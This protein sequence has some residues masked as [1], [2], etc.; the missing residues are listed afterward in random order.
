MVDSSDYATKADLAW[1]GTD[2]RG[3]MQAMRGELRAEMQTSRGELRAEMRDLRQ[4]MRVGFAELRTEIVR[5]NSELRAAF[6]D[7][8]SDHQR[9]VLGAILGQYALIIG[10]YGLIIRRLH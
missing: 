7:R 3:D 6:T 5:S 1:L 2:L 9:W 10:L 8:L 4:E